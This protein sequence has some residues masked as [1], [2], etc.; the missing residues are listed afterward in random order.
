MQNLLLGM[1]CNNVRLFW[2]VCN[3]QDRHKNCIHLPVVLHMI[4]DNKQEQQMMTTDTIIAIA[5]LLYLALWS[6]AVW[7]IKREDTHEI[8]WTEET[9]QFQAFLPLH[10]LLLFLLLCSL[11]MAFPSTFNFSKP[12]DRVEGRGGRDSQE[13]SDAQSAYPR[14]PG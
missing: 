5:V 1:D 13:T 10:F 6:L 14:T 11:S 3:I 9:L 12:N 7:A 2:Y 8:D 4:Y